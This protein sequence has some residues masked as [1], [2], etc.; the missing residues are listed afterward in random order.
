MTRPRRWLVYLGVAAINGFLALHGTIL[1]LLGAA[2]IWHEPIVKSLRLISGWVFRRAFQEG[3]SSFDIAAFVAGVWCGL[4]ALYAI[5]QLDQRQPAR[6]L[7]TSLALGTIQ[8]TVAVALLPFPLEQL[9]C[10]RPWNALSSVLGALIVLTPVS[11]ATWVEF[12]LGGLISGGVLWI[13]ARICAEAKTL[14]AHR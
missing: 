14:S 10:L 2:F 5:Q 13:G 1:Y 3:Y 4:V 6:V 12:L 9:L 11:Q 7:L 8:F